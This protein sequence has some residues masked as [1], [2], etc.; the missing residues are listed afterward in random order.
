MFDKYFT[1]VVTGLPQPSSFILAW[2]MQWTVHWRSLTG[3]NML[4]KLKH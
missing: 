2:D 4:S 3:Q 1:L